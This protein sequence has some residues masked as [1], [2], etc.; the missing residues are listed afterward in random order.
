MFV[1]FCENGRNARLAAERYRERYEA[2]GRRLPSFNTFLRLEQRFR[3]TGSV[4]RRPLE[5]HDNNER[6]NLILEDRI[7]NKVRRDPNIS[8]RKIEAEMNIPKSKVN[9]ILRKN[10]IHPY[11]YTKVQFLENE[12]YSARRRF[13]RWILRN[14]QNASLIFW[15]DESLFTREGMF[16]VHNEHY[17]NDENPYV[18]REGKMQ[19]RFKLNIWAGIFNDRIVGPYLLPETLSVSIILLLK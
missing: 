1:I 17:Y 2:A 12:D 14:P 6:R 9:R 4:C 19:K 13:S 3:E 11:H 16:N 5:R 7:F 8:C 10:K 15:T 18:Y